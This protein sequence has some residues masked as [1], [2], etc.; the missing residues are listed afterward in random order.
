MLGGP[1]DYY[2][3]VLGSSNDLT[4]LKT[5]LQPPLFALSPSLDSFAVSSALHARCP[6]SEVSSGVF[7]YDLKSPDIAGTQTYPVSVYLFYDPV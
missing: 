6:Y 7:A 3:D 2:F 4:H 5:V 1:R